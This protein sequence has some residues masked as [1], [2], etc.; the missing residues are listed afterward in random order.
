MRMHS[1]SL[2][3]SDS[4]TGLI[5]CCPLRSIA[6]L[7]HLVA[8]TTKHLITLMVSAMVLSSAPFF[9]HAQCDR[10]GTTTRSNMSYETTTKCYEEADPPKTAMGS[11]RIG[12]QE[13]PKESEARHQ[14]EQMARSRAK[15]P[16]AERPPAPS[17]SHFLHEINHYLYI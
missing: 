7:V 15:L 11:A 3:R 10:R 17:W 5:R 8:R 16:I 13:L 1:P 6:A 14:L 2:D 12:E 4:N 9:A